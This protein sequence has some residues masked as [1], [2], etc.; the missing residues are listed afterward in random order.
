MKKLLISLLNT[1]GV[2][3]SYLCPYPVFR[4][5]SSMRNRIYTGYLRRRFAAFGDS[6]IMWKACHLEGLEYVS[7]GDNTD[8]EVELQLTAWHVLKNKPKIVLGNGCLIRKGAHITAVNSVEIGN[9]LLTGTNVFITDNS[10]GN[11]DNETLHLAPSKREITSK[12]TVKIGND[13]WLGN[14]V[15]VLSGVTIGDGAVVGS[16]SVV[17]HDI[18]PYT[19]AAGVP[20]RILSNN[21]KTT[22]TI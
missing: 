20:A 17:T 13:V 2:I 1:T 22:R 18:P 4:A 14:N 10:H 11:T 6:V 8:I 3:L 5:L 16:N 7:I 12:G 19:V 9:N 21:K 15:C